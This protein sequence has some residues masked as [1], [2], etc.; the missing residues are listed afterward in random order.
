MRGGSQ[1]GRFESLILARRIKNENSRMLQSLETRFN[2]LQRN[3]QRILTRIEGQR[4]RA[5]QLLELKDYREREKREM[6]R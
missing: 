5:E 6:Q 4:Q 1:S 3:E 2:I